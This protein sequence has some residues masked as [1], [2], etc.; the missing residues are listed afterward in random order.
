MGSAFLT[1]FGCIFFGCVYCET[2]AFTNYV[3]MEKLYTLED[4][5]IT[6]TDVIL[7]QEKVL[8]GDE[9]THGIYNITR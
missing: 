8:H 7:R 6:I 3:N 5:L 4:D 2:G 1:M 9:D